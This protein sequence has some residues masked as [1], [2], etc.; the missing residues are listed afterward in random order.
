MPMPCHLC[1]S[2]HG[3]EAERRIRSGETFSTVAL[4]LDSQG[5]KV[6]R[7]AIARHAKAHMALPARQPGPRPIGGDFLTAVSDQAHQRMDAGEI[8]PGIRDGLAAAVAIENRAQ[9]G[10]DTALAIIIAQ[11]LGGHVPGSPS[12]R[13]LDPEEVEDAEFF[14]ALTAGEPVP[15]ALIPVHVTR[16]ERIRRAA[17]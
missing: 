5:E 17:H 7:N 11:A 10:T 4:W 15:S 2:A 14:A 3:R 6:S 16:E 1:N 8:A 9:R 12:V 13:V